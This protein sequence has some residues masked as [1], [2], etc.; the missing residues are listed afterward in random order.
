MHRRGLFKN[1]VH[2]SPL[3]YVLDDETRTE[4][5]RLFAILQE[6]LVS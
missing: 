2:R 6:V 1:Q 3:G 4:I 5:D